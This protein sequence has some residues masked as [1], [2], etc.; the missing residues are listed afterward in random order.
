MTIKEAAEI[1]RQFN[2]WRR[3]DGDWFD[4]PSQPEPHLIGLA[5]DVLVRHVEALP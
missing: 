3:W 5:I 2:E 4:G 1:L